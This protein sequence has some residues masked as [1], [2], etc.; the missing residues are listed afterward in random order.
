MTVELDTSGLVAG[1]NAGLALLSTPY[2]WIGVVKTA[3]GTTLQMLDATGVPPVAA[4]RPQLRESADD[5]SDQS[6]GHLWLRVACN[7]DTDQ[8]IFSW[9]A[10]GKAVHS[11]RQSIHHDLPAARL[12]KAFV[13][14]CSIST[15]PANRAAMPISTTTPLKSRAHGAS[16]AKFRWARPSPLPAAPMAVCWPPMRRTSS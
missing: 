10:D 5:R 13:P 12:S 4:A 2:A 14:R 3:E 6:T 11:V 1:D 16:N 9:S 15:R 7:F 8:A